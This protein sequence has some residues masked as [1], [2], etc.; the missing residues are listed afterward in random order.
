MSALTVF[1]LWLAG[2]V[3]V[4]PLLGWAGLS[5]RSG[6]FAALW[7]A[8]FF[9]AMALFARPENYYW[10]LMVLPLYFAGFALV[11]R[12]IG[13]LLASVTGRTERLN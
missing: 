3:A 6:W 2:P 1:P 12:A 11:P 10:V 5:G 8:G 4:L 9:L 7:S 13:D